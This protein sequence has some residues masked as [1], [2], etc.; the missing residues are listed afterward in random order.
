MSAQVRFLNN[1]DFDIY[2]NVVD[3][4]LV[5][6]KNVILFYSDKCGACK[7]FTPVYNNLVKQNLKGVNVCAVS[8][9]EN[10][11]L[12]DRVDKVF[13]FTIQYVPTI[14]SYDGRGYYSTYDYGMDEESN[15]RTLPDLI[16]Y[17][18][19]I[20]KAPIQYK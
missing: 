18:Q 20:G 11:E 14:V 15:F 2:G 8:V 5:K 6:G 16:E 19:G 1:K 3:T 10:P 17:I 13:P 7:S 12:M 9:A 4:D